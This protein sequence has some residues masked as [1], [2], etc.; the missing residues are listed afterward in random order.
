MGG[1]CQGLARL[2]YVVF[3]IDPL[4]QGERSQYVEMVDGKPGLTR[5]VLQ[6][7]YQTNTILGLTKLRLVVA[8]GVYLR[9]VTGVPMA[10]ESSLRSKGDAYR[11]YKARTKRW[12]P[13]IY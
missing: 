9:N 8:R 3:I 6:L 2:G 5:W 4:G 11:A 10:E 1:A 12:V 7:P 13:F